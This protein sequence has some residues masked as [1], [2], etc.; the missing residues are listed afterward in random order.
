MRLR[1]NDG[2]SFESCVFSM[3][4]M[5]DI[6]NPPI[7]VLR[8]QVQLQASTYQLSSSPTPK[9]SANDAQRLWQDISSVLWRKRNRWT[10][11]T[12]AKIRAHFHLGKAE[13][14][15][16]KT[17]RHFQIQLS[18]TSPMIQMVF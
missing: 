13:A 10:P 1:V 7:H 8:S 9:A 2:G 3:S 16:R 11:V 17:V 12:G 15:P 6:R 14:L 4:P 5:I 18:F